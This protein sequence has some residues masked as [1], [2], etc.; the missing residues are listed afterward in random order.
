MFS[1]LFLFSYSQNGKLKETDFK[2]IVIISV[3]QHQQKNIKM[4][5]KV[6][7][8]FLFSKSIKKNFSWLFLF[9]FSFSFLSHFKL[10]FY[11]TLILTMYKIQMLNL[12][13]Y[14]QHLDYVKKK[15]ETKEYEDTLFF[16]FLFL[17]Y[18][19]DNERWIKYFAFFFVRFIFVT[20]SLIL[21]S[22]LNKFTFDYWDCVFVFFPLFFINL[23]LFFLR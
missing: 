5:I 1:S 13:R 7:I 21:H 10:K 8:L 19:F 9:F 23:F 14:F 12:L 6:A 17:Y 11:F 20:H 16:S 3:Y 15:W 18:H 4:H 2:F 22:I